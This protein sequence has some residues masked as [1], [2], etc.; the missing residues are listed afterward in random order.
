MII[1]HNDDGTLRVVPTHVVVDT[2]DGYVFSKDSYGRPFNGSL[3]HMFA[4]SRNMEKPGT[5]K[6]F[7]LIETDA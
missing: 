6:A 3:A 2:R 4:N 7:Q 5:Y 1:T